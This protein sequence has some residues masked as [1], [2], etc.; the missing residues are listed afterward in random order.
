MAACLSVSCVLN[1]PTTVSIS[2]VFDMK[3]RYSCGFVKLSLSSRLVPCRVW[4]SYFSLLCSWETKYSK[5]T[6]NSFL[7]ISMISVL[8]FNERLS[9]SFIMSINF[10]VDNGVH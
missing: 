1:V 3:T 10:S 6:K 8:L 2:C 9:K 5:Q 4:Q 7:A